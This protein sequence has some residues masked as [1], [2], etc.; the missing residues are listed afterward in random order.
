M[1][2][3]ELEAIQYLTVQDILWINL[4][5]TKRS[6]PFPY[7]KLEEATFLQY[8]YGQSRDV[9]GQAAR[10]MKG[11]IAMAPFGDGDRE[12]A[13]LA[14]A[15]FLELN[16]YELAIPPAEAAAWIERVATGQVDPANALAQLAHP[17]H[18]HG[19][20]HAECLRE[21]VARYRDLLP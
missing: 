11:F 10:F 7:A 9:L 4:Q 18:G 13:F 6:N 1:S 19:N 16:G 15:A 3:A 21:T 17:A 2:T 8:A 20:G 14:G 12:T 5:V